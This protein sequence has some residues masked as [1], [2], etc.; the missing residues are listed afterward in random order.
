MKSVRLFESNVV[1]S[2]KHTIRPSAGGQTPALGNCQ[3][4]SLNLR[5]FEM[6]YNPDDLPLLGNERSARLLSRCSHEI[7]RC[8]PSV[9]P[10]LLILVQ[11]QLSNNVCQLVIRSPSRLTST[12]TLFSASLSSRLITNSHSSIK[13]FPKPSSPIPRRSR[14]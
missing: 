11:T 13:L 8:L 7:D 3:K 2:R 1:R 12:H 6:R 14:S 9:I 5:L 4:K 10:D